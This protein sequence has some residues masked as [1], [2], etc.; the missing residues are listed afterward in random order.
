[1]TKFREIE[2]A[3]LDYQ[4]E[5][6]VAFVSAPSIA[7]PGLVG[8]QSA[9]AQWAASVVER[10]SEQL[11]PPSVPDRIFIVDSFVMKAVS[12]KIDRGCLP[13]L[14]EVLHPTAA[15]GDTKA[16]V[17]AVVD[18]GLDDNGL[19]S[20]ERQ[21]VL[22]ICRSILDAPLCWD[23]EFIAAGA[24]SI[25]I[26]RLAQR[27][28]VAGWDVSVRSLVTE[29][30]TPRKVAMLPRRAVGAKLIDTGVE[31]AGRRQRGEVED[32]TLTKVLPIAHFSA[33]QLLFTLF[34]ASPGIALFLVAF[35][36]VEV[37][38]IFT[39]AQLWTFIAV[40]CGLYLVGLALPFVTLA[41]VMVI[42]FLISGSLKNNNL[43]SGAYPKWSQMHL[44]VWC[45]WRL[46]SAVLM[47]LAT[48]YRSA[49]LMAFA[50]RQLGAQIGTNLQCAHDAY[51]S[52]PLDLLAIEDDVSIQSGAYIQTTRWSGETLHVGSITLQSQCKVGMRAAIAPDVTIGKGAWVT[53]FSPIDNDVGPWEMWEGAP[54]RCVGSVVRLRR[55]AESCRCRLLIWQLETLN[56][57]FQVASFIIL[58]IVPTAAIVWFT[59]GIIPVGEANLSSAY[60]QT[61]AISEII[62]QLSL[63][64]FLVSW[65]SVCTT[66]VLSCLFIRLTALSPGLHPTRGLTGAL[67]LYRLSRMNAIQTTWTWTITGQ[68][69][70]AIAGVRFSRLGATECDVMFNLVPELTSADAKIFWSNGC[71]TNMLDY[72]T[73]ALTLRQ[74]SLP[75][76]FFSGNN[77][78][79]EYGQF[80]SNFL[81]GVSTP[82]NEIDYRRQ[83]R[84]RL[85]EPVSI[86]GNP[87]IKFASASFD[88]ENKNQKPPG[89]RL[90]LARIFLNDVFSIGI[91]RILEG[92]LFAIFYVSLMRYGV[93]PVVNAI[94]S[95]IL[96]EA[97]LVLASA[98]VKRVLVGNEWGRDDATP[99][100]SWK[101]FAY[102]FAQDCFFVWCR[103]VVG[104]C[105]GTIFANPILRLMGCRIGARTLMSEPM[106]ASDWNAVSFGKDCVINGFLQFH[107]FEN[108]TLKVKQCHVGDEC[109]VNFGAT[110][111]SGARVA[112]NSTLMPLSL[113]L[114]EMD[115]PSGI[116]EGSPADTI[117][118][119]PS[120]VQPQA[121]EQESLVRKGKV[122]RV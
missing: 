103:G 19:P 36:F 56:I 99:F 116:Y 108:M 73:E 82:A 61:A 118:C 33:L 34:F 98:S 6:L 110:I 38:T 119:A 105:A 93:N 83:M 21:E 13:D 59:R 32:Q 117:D 41:W 81:V 5:T 64:A 60:F 106:Q 12:G 68:Y 7:E 54:A 53:P 39:T 52:G 28:R 89:F 30:N 79:T 74:L 20:P 120:M 49:P 67:A 22:S 109:T 8:H 15:A 72:D 86:A 27:L 46:E 40:G 17:S 9:P 29:C 80:P 76:N 87:P 94:S 25:A 71:F 51:L 37:G 43:P 69:L 57:L 11:P 88:E 1:Q 85:E 112:S 48:M 113:V 58:N 75:K 96:T 70:R 63:Y 16:P 122:G 115:L 100:W 10:L 104:L 31:S 78:V 45:I 55:V 77:C 47:S 14:S 4:N 24:H 84:T 97:M 92:L 66:S 3:V 42:K 90:F 101:H 111:M 65:L 91:L 62:V 102:F 26:A 35:A 114:K 50:L 107:T 23:D 44:R 121:I 2:A 18:E 95:L